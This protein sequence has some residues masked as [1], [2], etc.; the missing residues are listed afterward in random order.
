MYKVEFKNIVKEQ[1][2]KLNHN[3]GGFM[4]ALCVPL[5]SLLALPPLPPLAPLRLPDVQQPPHQH[6]EDANYHD[7][8]GS[9]ARQHGCVAAAAGVGF[10]RFM[11][12]HRTRFNE[13][14]VSIGTRGLLLMSVLP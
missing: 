3:S 14:L 7:G 8:N 10:W 5:P 11:V 6:D 9:N 12:V 1:T 2:S 4:A 13:R